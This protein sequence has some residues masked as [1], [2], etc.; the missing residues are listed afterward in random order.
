V[1]QKRLRKNLNSDEHFD[2]SFSFMAME[3][4]PQNQPQQQL[5]NKEL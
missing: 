5:E 2:G 3:E 1:S 4:K